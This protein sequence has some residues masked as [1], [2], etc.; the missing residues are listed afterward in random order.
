MFSRYLTRT[1][2][3]HLIVSDGALIVLIILYNL[4]AIVIPIVKLTW[5][6]NFVVFILINAI[7]ISLKVVIPLLNQQ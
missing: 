6:A 3:R 1:F 2:F 4:L 5:L 7:L